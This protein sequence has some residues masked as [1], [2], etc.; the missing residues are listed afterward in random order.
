MSN[1]YEILEVS[2]KA[3]KE[4][5][6]KAYHVLVKKYHPDLQQGEEKQK[7]EEKMKQINEAYE[8]LSNEEKRREYDI[9]LEEQRKQEKIIEEQKRKQ[10]INEYEKEKT[11][12]QLENQ[13]Y[14]R[15]EDQN[16][17]EN[18]NTNTNTNEN[19]NYQNA[20]KI[21]KEI[22]RAY[23][24]AYNNYLRSLGYKV[25]EPWTFKRF[26]EL[27]KVLAI[28]TIIILIIWFFPPTNK[29]LIEFYE[30]NFIIKTIVDIILNIFQ[31]IWDGIKNFI[32][33]LF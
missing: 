13:T 8:I 1:L 23:A 22:N 32:V 2:E 3:S 31:G 21:Q 27:L 9:N 6:D 20:K 33:A 18:V 30:N 12:E 24:N 17:N 29:L 14:Y 19:N 15:N 11:Q 4:V 16:V 10:Q 25:K 26:L 5:I 28:L 7:A